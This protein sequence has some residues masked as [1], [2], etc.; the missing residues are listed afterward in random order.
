MVRYQTSGHG[1]SSVLAQSFVLI[2]FGATSQAPRTPIT[3]ASHGH[4]LT[5]VTGT[6]LRTMSNTGDVFCT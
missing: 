3:W 6:G 4:S 2:G 1:S 5:K